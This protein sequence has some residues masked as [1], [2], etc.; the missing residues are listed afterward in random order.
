MPPESPDHRLETHKPIAGLT[1]RGIRRVMARC[2]P[3]RSGGW[4]R[5]GFGFCGRKELPAPPRNLSQHLRHDFNS[6]VPTPP[7]TP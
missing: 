2:R 6:A 4:R 7:T 1:A 5:C 3:Y